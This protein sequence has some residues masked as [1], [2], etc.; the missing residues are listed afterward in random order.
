[1][2][3]VRLLTFRGCGDERILNGVYPFSSFLCCAILVC[4][5]RSGSALVSVWCK[6]DEPVRVGSKVLCNYDDR[7]GYA[8]VLEP[9]GIV[10]GHDGTSK[11]SY[12]WVVLAKKLDG[13][14]YRCNFFV[15]SELK[16][17]GNFDSAEDVLGVALDI[18]GGGA[19]GA[20]KACLSKIK[21]SFGKVHEELEK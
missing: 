2:K 6:G 10:V 1:M 9:I 17:L 5:F 8:E 15:E 21:K 11:L 14:G 3:L 18:S 4:V 12:P 13:V 16:V 19:R 20:L 7:D